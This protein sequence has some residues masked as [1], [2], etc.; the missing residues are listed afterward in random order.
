MKEGIE[1]LKN[2]LRSANQRIQSLTEENIRLQCLLFEKNNPIPE[3]IEETTTID[4][5]EIHAKAD[6]TTGELLK[7]YPPRRIN[8]PRNRSLPLTWGQ[9]YMGDS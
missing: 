8:P 2:S 7:K 3:D 1:E 9:Q 6:E 4:G 5:F